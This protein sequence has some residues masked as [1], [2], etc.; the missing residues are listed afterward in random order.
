MGAGI[1]SAGS[2]Y[3]RRP[4]GQRP[5]LRGGAAAAMSPELQGGAAGAMSAEL[6]G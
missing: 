4:S 3:V 2:V 5:E 1:R 6:R